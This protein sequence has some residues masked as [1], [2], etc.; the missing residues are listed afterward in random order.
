MRLFEECVHLLLAVYLIFSS[1]CSAISRTGETHKIISRI[2]RTKQLNNDIMFTNQSTSST[3]A[4]ATTSAADCARSRLRS[5]ALQPAHGLI[6]WGDARP[7]KDIC[8]WGCDELQPQRHRNRSTQPK[9]DEC[10][11]NITTEKRCVTAS[12]RSATCQQ[13]VDIAVRNCS[14]RQ[15][16][17]TRHNYALPRR[18]KISLVQDMLQEE[19]A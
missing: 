12:Q 3:C 14:S 2:D 19:T 6:F 9:Y 18:G 13:I 1:W 5:E 11:N 16:Q 4:S 8:T 15:T 7:P 17:N 10:E